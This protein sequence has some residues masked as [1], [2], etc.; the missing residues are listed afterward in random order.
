MKLLDKFNLLNEN[1]DK[2]EII[3]EIMQKHPGY[4]TEIGWSTYTGGMVDSGH[5]YEDILLKQPLYKLIGFLNSLKDNEK[6]TKELSE[7]SLTEKELLEKYHL[8]IERKL[9]WGK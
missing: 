1:K 6:K 4:G 9:M 7:D 8:E 3:D 2:F 5:W